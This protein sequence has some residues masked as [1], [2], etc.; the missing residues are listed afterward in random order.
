MSL[1]IIE[2]EPLSSNKAALNDEIDDVTA[3]PNC[4]KNYEKHVF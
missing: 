1:T 4:K 2:V 3:T